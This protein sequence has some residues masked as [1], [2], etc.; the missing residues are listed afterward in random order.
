M[1]QIHICAWLLVTS[2][3]LAAC[4]GEKFTAS[5]QDTAAHD[6]SPE[7]SAGMPS[8]NHAGSSS[9]GGF[10]LGSGGGQSTSAGGTSSGGAAYGGHATGGTSSTVGSSSPGGD[11]NAGGASS[12]ECPSG[13]ITFRMLPGPDLGEDFL[14]DAGC[15]T[16]W[17]TITD[18]EGA[19][20]FSIF[21]ACGTASCESCQTLA[22]AA[23]ACLPTPLTAQG[24]EL[25]WTGT[26]LAKDTCGA[27]MACQRQACVKPGKYKA[28]ACAAINGGASSNGS[29]ACTPKTEQLCAEAEFEFPATA[30]VKLVLRK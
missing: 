15:G 2:L 7:T 4:S 28:K 17:L 16:G 11:D 6:P 14:C 26:Y 30:T 27:N 19:T 10:S 21:S 9:A 22:C 12:D 8:R 5:E 3:T 1:R 25:V 23:A 13:A 24:S 18:V 29:Q 20:A